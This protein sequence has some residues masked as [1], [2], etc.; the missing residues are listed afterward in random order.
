MEQEPIN[1]T[2]PE[3][4]NSSPQKGH[5]VAIFVVLLVILGVVLGFVSM[6]A[7]DNASEQVTQTS[8]KNEVSPLQLGKEKEDI[9][10]M[11]SSPTPLSRYEKQRLFSFI[12][13]ERI[14]KYNFTQD[15]QMIIFNALTTD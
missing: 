14:L 4:G 8:T 15:E 2:G 12:E 11:A 5:P 3:L 7:K 9:L 6:Q 10:I 1:Q 13:G